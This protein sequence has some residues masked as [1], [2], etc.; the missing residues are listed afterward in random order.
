MNNNNANELVSGPK[1]LDTLRYDVVAKAPSDVALSGTDVD[2]DTLRAMLRALVIDRFKMK[3]HM[4][5]MPITFYALVSPKREPKLK[6]ADPNA[7]AT[8][9]RSVAP[10]A[11]GTP[12][13]AL[14]CQNTTMAQLVERLPSM[15]PAYFD[16]PAVDLTELEGGWDFVLNWTPRNA[17]GGGERGQAPNQ[18]GA[19]AADPNGSFSLSEGIEKLGLKLE[20]QKHAMP[21]L[22]IDQM[23]QKPTDN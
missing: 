13:A 4:E 5:K 11:T 3:F 14:T 6:K 19:A 17:L 8:C 16:H 1:F 22:V 15:A 23:E 18:G 7:R 21:V 9:K 10:N 20:L 12:L 2:E